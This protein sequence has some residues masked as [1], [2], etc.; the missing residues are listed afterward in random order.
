MVATTSWPEA[1][2]GVAGI[3]FI[4]AVIC[5]IVWQVFSTGRTAVATEGGKAF[6]KL[7]EEV[8]KAQLKT[9]EE[10]EK[11]AQELTGMRQ[12]MAELERLLKEVD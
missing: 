9:A 1:M 12:S 6:K 10:L 7:A 3:F 5:T 11:T 2:V 8:A 4:T